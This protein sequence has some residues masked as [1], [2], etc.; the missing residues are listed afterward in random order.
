MMSPETGSKIVYVVF[1]VVWYMLRHK[2]WRSFRKANVTRSVRTRSERFSLIISGIG[3]GILPL[4]HLLLE[5]PVFA[6]H[7][8]NWLLVI[9]GAALFAFSLYMFRR[10]HKDLGRN[11]SVSLDVQS[12]HTLV[13]EGVY[14]K[15]RHPMYT[16]FWLWAV[17][18]CLIVPNWI[19]GF[20]GI[21]GFGTLYLLRVDQ[22]E[23]M[24][25]QT[26]GDAYRG[27][28]ARTKRII[29]FLY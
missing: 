3:L 15:I 7:S 14:A 2:P 13:T 18:Q 11:W 20:A 26:F 17:A 6:N 1:L 27:Y 4:I 5:R 12:T 23:N 8:T 25:E 24:M 21:I 22:E 16:A 19:A 10:S 28:K 9:T 29:P